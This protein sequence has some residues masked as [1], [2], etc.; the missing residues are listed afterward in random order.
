MT[1]ALKR[2]FDAA[3]QL[4]EPDQDRLAGAILEEVAL[5]QQW[6]A[7]LVRS[8]KT[9]ERLADEAVAEHRAGATHSLDP[10]AL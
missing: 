2:A 6:D 7:A 3:S 4:P 10:D 8:R 9:L 1:K 5:T